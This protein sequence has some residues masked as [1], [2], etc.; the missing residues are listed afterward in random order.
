MDRAPVLGAENE[1]SAAD[2]SKPRR[3]EPARP[4]LATVTNAPGFG[5]AAKESA[6]DLG[7][8]RARALAGMRPRPRP[9]SGVGMLPLPAISDDDLA[10]RVAARDTRAASVLRRPAASAAHPAPTLFR[11]D[12]A[13]HF[14][15]P[16]LGREQGADILACLSESL[17][18]LS[19]FTSSVRPSPLTLEN[20]SRSSSARV[21]AGLFTTETLTYGSL[22]PGTED[23]AALF[24]SRRW[25]A[26]AYRDADPGIIRTLAAVT[27]GTID[28][29]I[30]LEPADEP[31]R[32]EF[33]EEGGDFSPYLASEF[34]GRLWPEESG[35]RPNRKR[36]LARPDPLPWIAA[37]QEAVRQ[38][39]GR[40][41]CVRVAGNGLPIVREFPVR[42]EK[43][44]GLFFVEETPAVTAFVDHPPMPVIKLPVSEPRRLKPSTPPDW[45]VEYL[46]STAS[47]LDLLVPTAREKL[48]GWLKVYR[49]D[50]AAIE[51]ASRGETSAH[52]IRFRCG[53][54]AGEFRLSALDFVPNMRRI[55]ALGFVVG[56]ST[57]GKLSA[58]GSKVLASSSFS[59]RRCPVARF[60][61]TLPGSHKDWNLA[62]MLAVGA[63]VDAGETPPVISISPNRKGADEHF[64]ELDKLMA[65]EVESG[66]ITAGHQHPLYLPIHV[67]PLSCVPKP[68]SDKFRKV[69]DFGHPRKNVPKSSLGP[70]YLAPNANCRYGSQSVNDWGSAQDVGVLVAIYELAVRGTKVEVVMTVRD[71]ADWYRVWPNQEGDLWHQQLLWKGKFHC[72]SRMVMGQVPSSA[73][74]T[75]LSSVMALIVL[76]RWDHEWAVLI[77]PTISRAAL[78]CI[79]KWQ[80]QRRAVYGDIVDQLRPVG[81]IRVSDDWTIV[82]IGQEVV[83]AFDKL[84]DVVLCGEL[85]VAMSPKPAANAPP[86]SECESVGARYTARGGTVRIA[87]R[88]QIVEKYVDRARDFLSKVNAATGVSAKLEHKELERFIGLHGYVCSFVPRGNGLR[89]SLTSILKPQPNVK[90]DVRLVR[91]NGTAVEDVKIMLDKCQRSD[92]MYPLRSPKV[93]YGGRLDLAADACMN[94]DR[95][96]GGGWGSL[97]GGYGS[98]GD[99]PEAIKVAIEARRVSIAFLEFY[100]FLYAAA[101]M[102]ERR[103]ELGLPPA[104]E[105]FSLVGRSD[106]IAVCF[107]CESR[108][109][110]KPLMRLCLRSLAELENEFNVTLY[111]DHIAGA[112]NVVPDLMSRDRMHEM[113]L[114]CDK[115]GI[116]PP[117]MLPPCARWVGYMEGAIKVVESLL[118]DEGDWDVEEM[119]R[120]WE[121]EQ[122]VV[123]RLVDAVDEARESD[124]E[125]RTDDELEASDT[126]ANVG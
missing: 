49:R 11:W 110:T 113:L 126:A 16:E 85:G 34:G 29:G 81:L 14:M 90:H 2:C 118:R 7:S 93:I 97:A 88:L 83:D 69:G 78:Q 80:A 19:S 39:Q 99:W 18:P 125:W 9:V 106:N 103:S 105:H 75:R 12:S 58:V 4:P 28:D 79:E 44:L 32:P 25:R 52:R 41:L 124:A 1:S 42:R 33:W 15:L 57:D 74:G 68:G 45:V 8:L 21:L 115:E 13:E 10:V 94:S 119:K 17:V 47:Y 38:R 36:R 87:P 70:F 43:A 101:I 54:G 48:L 89:N 22:A 37:S 61:M 95:E 114:E 27:S 71:L 24:G 123:D 91:K 108:L 31:R 82:G 76:A 56:I 40:T 111:A 102:L 96:S 116:A 86:A 109:A 92:F 46:D 51:R 63:D 117:I 23:E 65:Q 5:T 3:Q 107:L 67:A 122:A 59:F 84:I 66:W 104:S 6:L 35:F 120:A 30:P 50:A 100:A 98:M 62:Q 20:A 64:A 26:S 77:K 60:I 55:V 72:D 112:V 73:N 121:E 53:K